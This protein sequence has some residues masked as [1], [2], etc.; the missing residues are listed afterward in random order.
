MGQ[1]RS[2]AD[3]NERTAQGVLVKGSTTYNST[4][5]YRSGQDKGSQEGNNRTGT[6]LKLRRF[7]SYD[8]ANPIIQ[9]SVYGTNSNT[10][11]CPEETGTSQYA[12]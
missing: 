7:R 12:I 8:T 5:Q 9:V 1:G 11:C 3:R 2:G 6:G 4:M 10:S